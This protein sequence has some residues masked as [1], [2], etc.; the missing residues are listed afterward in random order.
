MR[1]FLS[2][3]LLVTVSSGAFAQQR[4][5]NPNPSGNNPA[6]TTGGRSG[7]GAAR[8]GTEPPKPYHE[9]ITDKATSHPGLFTVHKVEDKWYCETPASIVSRDTLVSTRYDRTSAGGNYGGEQVNVQTIRWEKGPAHTVFM[10]VQTIVNVA[11][12]S[13]QPIAQAV[14][15]SNM[16]PIAAEF[17]VKAYGKSADSTSGTVVIDVTDFFKGDNQVVSLTPGIKRRFNLSALAADRSYIESIHTYP[18]NTEIRTVKT[19]IPSQ[20]PS[21]PPV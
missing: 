13:S 11:T 21:G 6:A 5:G 10:N 16:D 17:D 7:L 20:A 19:F 4:P 14:R 15:N 18:L 3:V 9:V 1:N 12:D 2:V 8:S